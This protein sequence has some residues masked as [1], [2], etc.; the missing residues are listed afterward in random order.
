MKLIYRRTFIRAKSCISTPE[1]AVDLPKSSP[2][3]TL[4]GLT[5]AN[6]VGRAVR[7]GEDEM[8]RLGS[9]RFLA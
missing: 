4:P 6:G 8:R 3:L 2:K 5:A 1:G 9:P 7:G